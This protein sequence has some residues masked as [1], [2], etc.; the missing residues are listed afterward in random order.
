MPDL[1]AVL[2]DCFA[3]LSKEYA[4][5]RVD[6]VL[7]HGQRRNV[8]IPVWKVILTT[9]VFGK[10]DDVE[11]FVAFPKEFPYVLPT[12]IV[13]DE[14]FCYLPHI[15]VK[16]RK[17]CLYED[18]EVYGIDNIY[19]LIRE[20]I[21]KTRR[22]L[23]FYSNQDNSAEYAKEIN[24][25]WTEKYEDEKD[26]DPH[27]I[28]LGEIPDKTCEL[29]GY[30]YPVDFLGENDK[31]FDQYIVCGTD[32][33][34]DIL[35][36]IKT[37][38]KAYKL[39][40]LFIKSF[41]IPAT[42]PYSMTGT[43]F[44]ECI[45]DAEDKRTCIK[46]LNKHLG[47]HFLFPLGLDFMLGGVT[48]P[49]QNV[50]KKGYRPGSLTATEVLTK[51]DGRNQKL[52]RIEARIYEEN[53]MA[54]RT[55]GQLMK[56]QNYVIVGLGSVG[57]NLCYFLN[58]YNN[59]SFF[60]VDPDSLTIDN[61]GRH[62]L[63]FN[64]IDQR[65]T[66]AVA[67]YLTLYRPDRQV[68]S[69]ARR[70]EELSIEEIN[71]ASALFMCTGDV[72]SERWMLDKMVNNEISVPAFILWLEPYGLSGV[73]V[74]VNPHEEGSIKRLQLAA[75]DG[76]LHYCLIDRAEYKT[77]EKLI[78]RDSGCNGKYAQYSA[79]DVTLFLSGM[80]PHIDRLLSDPEKTKIYQWVGNIEIAVQKGINLVE[81]TGGL[82]K[83]QVLSL[84]L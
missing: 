23:F 1:E 74:Y 66:N 57:S 41:R 4:V 76:F 29:I 11:A 13:P 16:S 69:A 21:S 38:H 32:K 2:T 78:K 37:R 26:L 25:Y 10:T 52:T 65:K 63:G 77:G 39:P 35:N 27:W 83:N 15:S 56:R 31:Y 28:L 22:W 82:S 46:Y 33:Q 40:V 59:A 55:A 19:G 70:I 34:D 36:N 54:E 17:L 18:G 3:E 5:E 44:L 14:R 58:G 45:E 8:T 79:N 71:K 9:K 48:I 68:D 72:M 49:K 84:P 20:H 50:F 30:T 62:L 60:L 43:Q 7:D 53:R 47:G 51:Y 81:R 6:Y 42:P 67:E 61:I 80:F 24:S 64:H 12:V 75:D 73:M